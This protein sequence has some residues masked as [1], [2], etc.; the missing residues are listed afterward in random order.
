MNERL[1]IG[2][3]LGHKDKSIS[4]WYFIVK[5][6]EEALIVIVRS[7]FALFKTYSAK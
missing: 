1:H 6:S 7:K 4:I 2:E 3:P 5:S